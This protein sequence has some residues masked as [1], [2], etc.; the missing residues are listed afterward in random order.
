[1]FWCIEW[2]DNHSVNGITWRDTWEE[3]LEKFLDI[4]NLDSKA[5]NLDWCIVTTYIDECQPY[6]DGRPMLTYMPKSEYSKDEL[7]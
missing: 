6:G 4:V 2:K 1:M 7:P 3:T 5:C